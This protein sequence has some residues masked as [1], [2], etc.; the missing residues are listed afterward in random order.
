MHDPWVASKL[1]FTSKHGPL[2]DLI[3][4]IFPKFACST[5]R[6]IRA[7][8]KHELNAPWHLSTTSIGIQSSILGP[9]S[10]PRPP[11]MIRTIE[12]LT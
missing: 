3:E 2:F 5:L 11:D 12:A 6:H 10:S 7:T 9:T 1:T 4:G 8:S